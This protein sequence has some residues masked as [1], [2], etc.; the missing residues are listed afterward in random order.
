MARVISTCQA[1]LTAEL[2]A[3]V[4]PPGPT[5]LVYIFARKEQVTLMLPEFGPPPSHRYPLY[6]QPVKLEMSQPDL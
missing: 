6:S 5:G 4:F 1:S 3:A 2:L